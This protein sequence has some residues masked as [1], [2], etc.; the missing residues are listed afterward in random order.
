MHAWRETTS[1]IILTIAH[2][3]GDDLIVVLQAANGAGFAVM[4]GGS[5]GAAGPIRAANACVR[6]DATHLRLTL[7]TPL[8]NPNALLFYPYGVTAIERGNAVTDNAASRPK[9]IG[10]DITYDLGS[11]WSLNFP[12][13]ASAAP[14]PV[15]DTP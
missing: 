3:T 13:A 8:T 4:D 6:V 5:A 1:S 14:I 11:A 2:D 7:V 10:W 9:P 12:L 15:S